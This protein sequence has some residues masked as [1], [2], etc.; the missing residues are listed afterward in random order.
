M[1][2]VQRIK[3]KMLTVYNNYAIKRILNNNQNIGEWCFFCRHKFLKISVQENIYLYEVH[4][5]LLKPLPPKMQQ[6]YH[7][8]QFFRF[9]LLYFPN[10]HCLK[11]GLS[12]H[13]KYFNFL[14]RWRTFSSKCVVFLSTNMYYMKRHKNELIRLCWSQMHNVHCIRCSKC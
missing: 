11:E 1:I 4:V 2:A 10:W 5:L 12:K 8:G 9:S 13:L 6:I 7:L 14:S 3:L